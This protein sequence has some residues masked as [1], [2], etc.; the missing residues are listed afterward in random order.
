MEFQCSI[1]LLHVDRARALELLAA[2][3]FQALPI[4]ILEIRNLA[5]GCF[6]RVAST[7]T[8]F[9]DPLEHSHVFAVSRPDEF[10]IGIG[11]KPIDAEYA[12]ALSHREIGRASCRE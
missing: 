6:D 8:A 4:Q 3:A 1:P 7:L 11:A 2:K 9:H 12:R 5:D 10:S